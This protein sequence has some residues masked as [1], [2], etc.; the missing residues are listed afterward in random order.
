[1]TSVAFSFVCLATPIAFF[2]I[3][4]KYFREQS[5]LERSF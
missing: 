1:V 4:T 3:I 5:L 2:S